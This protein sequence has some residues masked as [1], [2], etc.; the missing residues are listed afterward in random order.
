MV[1]GG[2][3]D[4]GGVGVGLVGDEGA[5]PGALFKAFVC[6][7]VEVGCDAGCWY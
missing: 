1:V 6:V 5:V 7:L 4:A 2:T 3:G